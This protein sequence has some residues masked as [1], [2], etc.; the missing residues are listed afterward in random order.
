MDARRV[1]IYITQFYL[2]TIPPWPIPARCTLGGIFFKWEG[3]VLSLRTS[4]EGMKSTEPMK[5]LAA[6]VTGG[7]GRPPRRIQAAMML[8]SRRLRRSQRQQGRGVGR[9]CGILSANPR[10]L[11]RWWGIRPQQVGPCRTELIAM[12]P[13]VLSYG[14]VVKRRHVG[15][16]TYAYQ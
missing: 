4:A 11:S 3:C 13:Q 16:R 8:V 14:T 6:A 5:R 10:N 15:S 1:F 9:V 7:E 12:G 2:S